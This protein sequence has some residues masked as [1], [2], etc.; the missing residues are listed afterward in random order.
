MSH[1]NNLARA[2]LT[3]SILTATNAHTL[4]PFLQGQQN[5]PN[6]DDGIVVALPCQAT[7]GLTTNFLTPANRLG[8]VLA[9]EQLRPVV[10]TALIIWP[11]LACQVIIFWHEAE[12]IL[13]L[14]QVIRVTGVF[15][16]I[17]DY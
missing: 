14:D 2:C 3:T 7:L 15:T 10:N 13:H 5:L 8:W 11:D 12:V 9:N 6:W 16:P 4:N 1:Q 17:S